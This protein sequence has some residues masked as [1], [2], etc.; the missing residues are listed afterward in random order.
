[1]RLYVRKSKNSPDRRFRISFRLYTWAATLAAINLNFSMKG[2]T[3]VEIKT[4]LLTAMK[5]CSIVLL[6]SF[7][8]ASA[9]AQTPATGITPPP[10][11]APVRVDEG[12]VVFLVGHATG[13]QNYSC[14]PCDPS[15]Q[16]CANGV[17]FKLFTPQ[18][19]LF[20]DE[21]E[22]VTTHFFSPNPFENGVIRATW[23]HSR[24]TSTVWGKVVGISTDANFVKPGA[25][26]WLKVQVKDVGVLA[27]P[28]G[29]DKLTETTFIQRLNTVGGLA[30]SSGCS[31]Q[32]D[33]GR[34]EF[35]P[36]K[37][38]YFFYKRQ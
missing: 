22:Q 28:T 23:Q 24:D 10:V 4:N 37:A 3:T 5:L 35:V 14:L 38:D 16:G 7:V 33:I 32:A 8:A 11:P 12:N 13:T 18:A 6:T 21:L 25:I 34:Q 1:M 17:A 36:Y 15:E 2:K 26:A 19:T 9:S 29:G 31:S 27:G 20:N 30:P